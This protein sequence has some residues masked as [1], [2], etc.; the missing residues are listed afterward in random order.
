MDK[1]VLIVGA[2]VAFLALGYWLFSDASKPLPG[3]SF[4][5]LEREHVADIYGVEYNSNPP[6]SGKHFPVWVKKG[7]YDRVISDG[8]LIHSLEHGYVVISY[9]CDYQKRTSDFSIFNSQFSIGAR[10]HEENLKE[11][12]KSGEATNSGTPLMHL[13]TPLGGASWYTPENP[14]APEVSLPDSFKTVQ[15]KNLVEQLNK[16]TR[17]ADRVVV[18]PRPKLDS[19]V[20]LTAWT[21]MLKLNFNGDS[22]SE[23]Q[24][25]QAKEFIKYW[26]NKGPEKTME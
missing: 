2:V 6:T 20:A 14:P 7:V 15:C 24:V 12:T 9:N 5:D 23:D 4:S 11:G 3:E 19:N 13:T 22:L 8:Y 21:K 16:L 1:R 18:V 25:K 10:A 26:Q 17:E